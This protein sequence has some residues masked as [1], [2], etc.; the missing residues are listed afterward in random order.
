VP[1]VVR[2][3]IIAATTLLVGIIVLSQ[4]VGVAFNVGW[5][6]LNVSVVAFTRS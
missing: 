1:R 2:N 5:L 3:I 6:R 4:W